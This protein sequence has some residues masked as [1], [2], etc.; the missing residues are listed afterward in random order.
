MAILHKFKRFL[1]TSAQSVK[2]GF[3]IRD[4]FISGGMAMLFYGLYIWIP[5]VA[6]SVCG[7][8]LMTMGYFMGE[9]E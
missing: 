4:I 2:K 9:S 7:T 6:F 5:W 8:L 1:S 3:G